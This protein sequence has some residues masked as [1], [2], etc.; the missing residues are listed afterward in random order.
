MNRLLKNILVIGV[1]ILC[2]GYLVFAGERA[3]HSS[4][5]Q[6]CSNLIIFINDYDKKMLIS[7]GEI[8]VYLKEKGLNPIGKKLGLIK[9]KSIED[10]V[11]THP[12]VRHAECFKTP[13]GDIRVNITQRTPI[14]RIIGPENYYVDD[15]RRP[16]PLSVNHTAYVPVFSGNITRKMATSAIFEF[17]QFLNK[18][19]FWGNQIAQVNITQNMKVQLVPRIGDH[20]I[21]LGNF[22]RYEQKL[23]KLR[24][25]Y[26]YGLNEIGWNH[27]SQ[28]D[29]Q[30]RDQ[31]VCTR[32]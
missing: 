7:D 13:G 12:M 31:V 10:A 11:E 29:L 1:M 22:D 16:I 30:F 28:I 3:I 20:I 21:M 24:K 32:R 18:D 5:Q 25:F 15:L 17:A 23:E 8:A 14:L 27:Y 6:V 26:L 9:T 19:E 2:I 4:R